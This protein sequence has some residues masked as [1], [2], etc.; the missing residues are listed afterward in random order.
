MNR[1]S[2]RPSGCVLPVHVVP[3]ASRTEVAGLHGGS[4]K[5]RL[6]APPVD[7]KANHALLSFIAGRLGLPASAVA[8]VGGESGREKR[9][10]IDGVDAAAALAKLQGGRS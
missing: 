1:P 5:I 2:P 7:G 8:L 3:R 10:R 4:V 6:Q 9:V